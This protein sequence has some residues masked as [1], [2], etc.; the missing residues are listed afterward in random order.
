[1]TVPLD[2]MKPE[3]TREEIERKMDRLAR[4]YAKT[5]DPKIPQE[6]YRLRSELDKMDKLEKQ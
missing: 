2:E 1:M 6:L 5:H 3:R 4:E